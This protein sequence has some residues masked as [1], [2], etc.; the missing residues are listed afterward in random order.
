MRNRQSS[1]FSCSAALRT[2]RHRS[3]AVLTCTLL[4][5][6]G[7]PAGFAQTKQQLE[8]QYR[9]VCS[10]PEIRA[11]P[12]MAAMCAQLQGLIGQVDESR[13]KP[14]QPPPLTAPSKARAP[15]GGPQGTA[16]RQAIAEAEEWY[17]RISREISE[18]DERW[19]ATAA[20]CRDLRE[21]FEAEYP[22]MMART[23]QGYELPSYATLAS[24]SGASTRSGPPTGSGGVAATPPQSQARQAAMSGA[25]SGGRA[26]RVNPQ[27]GEP[28]V[29]AAQMEDHWETTLPGPGCLCKNEYGSCRDRAIRFELSNGCSS[30][31]FVRWQFEGG[32][33][34]CSGGD[35]VGPGRSRPVSCLQRETGASGEMSYEFEPY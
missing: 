23:P 3:A 8:Q 10:N 21:R 31:Y 9:Q 6:F 11:D 20:K 29:T 12:A 4:L 1:Y 30:P 32:G 2:W 26:Q 22:R 16:G 15:T 19:S 17:V 25:Q 27:T 18:C 7:S 13:L 35:I 34:R 24:R 33:R 28:C 14:T 5:A